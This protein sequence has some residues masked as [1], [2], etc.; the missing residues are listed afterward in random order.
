MKRIESIVVPEN[1]NE[2]EKINSDIYDYCEER[3]LAWDVEYFTAGIVKEY[4]QAQKR[5]H[6]EV[7][8]AFDDEDLFQDVN[9]AA[10]AV[11]MS[12]EDFILMLLQHYSSTHYDAILKAWEG[13]NAIFDS[14]Q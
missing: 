4:L 8:I 12:I 2:L 7:T 13:N 3:S 11:E 5:K 10:C 14:I 1:E 9:V 6:P